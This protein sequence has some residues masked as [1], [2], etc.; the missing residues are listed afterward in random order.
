MM[1]NNMVTKET[2]SGTDSKM[3]KTSCAVNEKLTIVEIASGTEDDPIVLEAVLRKLKNGSLFISWTAGGDTEPCEKNRTMYKR[4]FNNGK[5]WERE[6]ILFQHSVKGMFTPCLFSDDNLLYAFP[7]S[8]FD[9]T[10][11]LQDFQSYWSVSEDFGETFSMPASFPGCINNIHIKDAIRIGKRILLACSWRELCGHNWAPP[12]ERPCIVAGEELTYDTS[13]FDQFKSW[14]ARGHFEYCGVMISDDDGKTWK[15]CGRLGLPDKMGHISFTEPSLVELSDGTLAMYIR[16]NYEHWIYESHSTDCGETWSK[17][18]RTDIPSA[19]SKTILLRGNDG[20]IYMLF[21]PNPKG[22][23]RLELW[24]SRDDLKTWEEKV[25]LV[26][27]ENEK[28][29]FCYPDGFIDEERGR[30]CFAWETRRK[31]YYS[32]YPIEKLEH[33][34]E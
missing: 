26:S 33:T 28:D 16:N 1:E 17:P 10:T 15:I 27:S 31:V 34:E 20:T 21:N 14:G 5:T 23:N 30:I 24:I 2:V 6:K 8:Y 32:E 3:R 13:E 4:S 9:Q 7:G 11:F 29:V 12:G 19:I 18:V 22:R 25:T